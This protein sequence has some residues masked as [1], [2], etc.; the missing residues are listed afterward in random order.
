VREFWRLSGN[1]RQFAVKGRSP[2][3][4]AKPKSLMKEFTLLRPPP[5]AAR[6]DETNVHDVSFEHG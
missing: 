2:G 6:A 4:G 3:V 5:D 1:A